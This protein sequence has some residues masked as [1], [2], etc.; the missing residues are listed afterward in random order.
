MAD[1]TVNA[2]KS[3]ILSLAI[4]STW[5]QFTLATFL[6][7]GSAE[8]PFKPDTSINWIATGGVLMI[9]SKDLSTYTVITTGNTLPGLS[10]VRAL[11]CLQNSMIF[12]PFAPNAGPIGGDGFAAPPLTCN[13]TIAPTSF[14]IF[15]YLFN[16]SK[17]KLSNICLWICDFGFSISDLIPA[18][19]S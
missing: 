15:I 2:F 13:F 12:T 3:V 4:V 19:Q 17:W 16:V 6:R 18:S 5:L 7:L 10:W 9:K 14:A 8:P 11:N 1:S